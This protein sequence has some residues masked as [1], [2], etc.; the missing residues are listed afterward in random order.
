MTPGIGLCSVSRL[1]GRWNGNFGR[2]QDWWESSTMSEQQEADDGQL[3]FRSPEEMGVEAELPDPA[4]LVIENPFDPDKIKI[5]TE[6]KTIDLIVRRIRY[7]EIDL[8]PEFQRRARVWTS[9]RK[10]QLIESL[11]LKI[12]LPVFYVAADHKDEW[13]VVDGLQ[14][15]TTILDFVE[16]E[17]DLDGL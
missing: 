2:S 15:L 8:A 13:A 4:P 10:S 12:P 14:R 7:G 11:L 3:G 17:F 1:C 5:S 9:Q 6:K 16:G